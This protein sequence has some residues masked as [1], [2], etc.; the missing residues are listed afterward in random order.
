MSDLN[1]VE[2]RTQVYWE[3]SQVW[4]GLTRRPGVF[5]L[6]DL[7]TSI[8]Q[9]MSWRGDRVDWRLAELNDYVGVDN[10]TNYFG[11]AKII[12]F[13]SQPTVRKVA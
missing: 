4:R 13:P 5:T 6:I 10:V 2:F 12:Q 11:P 9:A 1:T 3:C 8:Q 7:F